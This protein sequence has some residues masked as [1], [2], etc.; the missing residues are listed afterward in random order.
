[1]HLPVPALQTRSARLRGS[2][3]GLGPQLNLNIHISQT[4]QTLPRHNIDI[5]RSQDQELTD[6][7]SPKVPRIDRQPRNPAWIL[8]PNLYTGGRVCYIYISEKSSNLYKTTHTNH[9]LPKV[10]GLAIRIT[11]P[12]CRTQGSALREVDIQVFKAE[13]VQE[14]ALAD[15]DR[16]IDILQE[17]LE[18]ARDK[19]RRLQNSRF[20]S[21]EREL[22]ISDSSLEKKYDTLVGDIKSMVLNLTRSIDGNFTDILNA[23]K[24]NAVYQEG[25]RRLLE[26]NVTVQE[27]VNLL[28]KSDSPNKLLAF[29]IRAIILNMLRLK[30]FNSNVFLCIGGE[31][32]KQLR[33]V[34]RH[35]LTAGLDIHGEEPE[36]L[37]E[38]G[39]DRHR[40][41]ASLWRSQTLITLDR[42][43]D[44][45]KLGDGQSAILDQLVT[46]IEE[47]LTPLAKSSLQK[48]DLKVNLKSL[49]KLAAELS[50]QLGK[51]RAMFE[52]EPKRY[53][54]HKVQKGMDQF[55]PWA[56]ENEGEDQAN[57]RDI[58]AVIVPA[59]FKFGNDDGEEFEQ[60]KIV[61]QAQVLVLPAKG[62]EEPKPSV[63]T[64]P[65]T[66]AIINTETPPPPPPSEITNST[67]PGAEPAANE[68]SLNP[69]TV[70]PSN[71]ADVSPPTSTLSGS[72]IRAPTPPPK[73]DQP[74]IEPPSST[75]P[76]RK[77]PE[78]KVRTEDRPAVDTRKVR[79]PNQKTDT[80]PLKAK[81][82]KKP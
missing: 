41:D 27:F 42:N 29:I 68:L 4:I 64:V 59:L 81:T 14:R 67:L 28:E 82:A 32:W 79:D 78:P 10:K 31:N 35:L 20:K 7:R 11:S 43:K 80:T 40:R 57:P 6:D 13:Q 69:S 44:R 24:Q 56:P 26:P 53:I 2:T 9:H 49:V 3:F 48:E 19:L 65:T 76:G 30:L 74:T 73:D 21:V 16:T 72:D 15:R 47:L 63:D 18:S 77:T 66:S 61:R 51:Q 8:L 70:H 38:P 1:M 34:Y 23:L 22:A 39:D 17:E 62:S 25:L 12:R 50:I 75:C 60:H 58:L 55:G 37:V 36:V 46:D 52:L 33:G 54:G 71:E 45:L 5:V